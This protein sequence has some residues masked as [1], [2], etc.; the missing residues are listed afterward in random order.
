ML[1]DFFYD[2]LILSHIDPSKLIPALCF[3]DQE[4]AAFSEPEVKCGDIKAVVGFDKGIQAFAFTFIGVEISVAFE[5]VTAD[6]STELVQ[7]RE[8]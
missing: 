7:G 6:S 3:T 1:F 2:D 5:T 8:A 4:V